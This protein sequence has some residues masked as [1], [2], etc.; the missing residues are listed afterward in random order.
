VAKAIK[1]GGL[2]VGG[3]PLMAPFGAMYDDAQI[4]AIVA[5]LKTFKP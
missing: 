2:A 4:A 1:E 5:H 3:S